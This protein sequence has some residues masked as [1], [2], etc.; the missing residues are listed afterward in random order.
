M[1]KV[2]E[3]NVYAV[4]FYNGKVLVLKRKNGIWEFPG[5]GVD[6]GEHPDVSI[7]REVKEETGL[8]ITGLKFLGITSATYEKE[9]NEKHSLYAVY[10]AEANTELVKIGGEHAEYRWL[11][12]EELRFLKLG[13]NA[14][15]VLDILKEKMVTSHG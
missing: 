15:P 7:V 14:E 12:L 9:G 1:V 8:G 6:W 13:L 5:G 11:L 2:Q 3:L 10:Q 4:L